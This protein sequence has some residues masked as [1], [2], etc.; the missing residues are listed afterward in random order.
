MKVNIRAHACA[1]NIGISLCIAAGVLL[2]A[3]GND[4][5]TAQQ[6]GNG[7]PPVPVAVQTIEP[8]SVDVYADYPGRIRGARE[9]Q[10]HARVEGNLLE[11]HYQ[12]GG[13]VEKGDLLLTID[14]APLQAAVNQRKAQL[15]QAQA[16]LSE[17]RQT[18]N[19]TSQLYQNNAAS[20][21]ERDK[22]KA[23]L[24]TARAGVQLAEANL[25]SAQIDLDYTTVEAPLSGVTSLQ[26]IDEGALVTHGTLLTTITQLDP[27]NVLFSLP[28]RDARMRQQALTAMGQE[29]GMMRQAD[30]LLPSGEIYAQSGTVDFTQ[31]TINPDTG[32]VRLRAQF[33]NDLHHL[34]PGQF[35]RIRIRLETRSNAIVVPD[36]AIIDSQQTTQVYVVNEDDQAK[37]VPVELGPAV[38]D[39]RIIEK[40]LSPGDRVITTGIGG[41]R[42]NA[43]VRIVPASELSL[44]QADAEQADAEQVDAEQADIEQA[45]EEQAGSDEQ[46]AR[47]PDADRQGS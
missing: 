16:Q 7:M 17:A 45:N 10:V 24:E 40:G 23:G 1:R 38:P 31:S 12:E 27:V 41:V 37:P 46:P 5:A 36:R 13:M 18:W 14:P 20:K 28:A 26:E 39:G 11:R 9:V 42:P 8:G 3:C 43:R 6:G 19:R 34:V 47:K 32:T 29:N 44:E 2:T 4:D 30:L 25:D 33:D 22:A 15:A 21:A 35:V